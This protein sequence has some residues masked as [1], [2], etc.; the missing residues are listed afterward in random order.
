LIHVSH[1]LRF[2]ESLRTVLIGDIESSDSIQ[3]WKTGTTANRASSLDRIFRFGGFAASKW[4]SAGQPFGDEGGS[5][6]F[7]LTHDAVI[8]HKGPGPECCQLFAS[9]DVISFGHVDLALQS[10]LSESSSA[11]ENSSGVGWPEG[12]VEEL[13][14]LAGAKKASPEQVGVW[15]S[16]QSIKCLTSHLAFFLVKRCI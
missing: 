15:D 9:P 10:D 11:L 13:T 3:T 5:F 1:F 8:P 14:F 4:K 7:S 12:E 2:I 16:I 6:L